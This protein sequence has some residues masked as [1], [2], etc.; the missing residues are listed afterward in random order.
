ML[1]FGKESYFIEY[2]T[3]KEIW[4]VFRY[5]FKGTVPKY[6]VQN[7]GVEGWCAHIYQYNKRG[8][9]RI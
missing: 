3:H 8:L 4:R 5:S 9:T 6:L 7:R 1:E 2:P